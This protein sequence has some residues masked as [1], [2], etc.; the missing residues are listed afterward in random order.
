MNICLIST[1]DNLKNE[2][3]H[4]GYFEKTDIFQDFTNADKYD[5]VIISDKILSSNDIVVNDYTFFSG[6]KIYYMI[7]NYNNRKTMENIISIC[8]SK[9]I[10][11]IPPKLS[12]KEISSR[13]IFDLFPNSTKN[14][15]VIS[16]FGADSKVGTTI[17]STAIAETLA[18]N[19]NAKVMIMFLSGQRGTS[20]IKEDDINLGIDEIKIK[21]ENQI[22]SKD[23]LLENCIKRNNLY[24]LPGINNILDIRHFKPENIEYL[25]SLASQLANIIIIDCGNAA[26]IDFAGALSISGLNIGRFKYLVT[27]QQILS[28]D[29]FNRVNEQILKILDIKIEDFLLI[30]NKYYTSPG[31]PT[32]DEL[33]KKYETN[34]AGTVPFLDFKGW[35]AEIEKTTLLNDNDFRNEIIDIAKLISTQL[36]IRYIEKQ[37]QRNIF[38]KLFGK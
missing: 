10:N 7:S 8:K 11:I 34:L 19:T 15:N 21:L 2:L 22:L 36:D 17:I 1:D 28:F 35:E 30:V 27:T 16:I 23:E 3:Q 12:I 9:R 38:Q 31:I 24:I 32:H 13:I 14:S 25:I 37:Y 29:I 33:C 4:T 6:R 26:N 5:I 18:N 20:F